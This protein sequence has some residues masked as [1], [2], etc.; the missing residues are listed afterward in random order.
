MRSEH[1][2]IHPRGDARAAR[3]PTFAI[4]VVIFLRLPVP[5]LL[6]T[7]IES[8]PVSVS[9]YGVGCSITLLFLMLIAVFLSIFAFKWKMTKGMG[10]LMMVLY[11]VFVVISLG[12][13]YEWYECPI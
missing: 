11:C 4:Y 9:S 10:A 1:E 7:L 2:Y 6:W 12:F 13:S 5:W 8:Q 3:T